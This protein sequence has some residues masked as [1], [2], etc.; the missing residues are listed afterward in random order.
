MSP[1]PH[2]HPEPSAPR[3][4]SG[5]LGRHAPRTGGEPVTAQSA[6]RLRRL[7]SVIFLPVFAAAAALFALWARVSGPGGSPH[8]AVL[9]TIAALC[10]ILAFLAVVDLLVV[11]RRL[12]RERGAGR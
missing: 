4:R 11:V 7:L 6:L 10:A 3:S 2:G 9:I 8:R 1:E 12:R 5:T